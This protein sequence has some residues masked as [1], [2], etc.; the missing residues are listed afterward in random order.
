VGH[1][2]GRLPNDQGFDEWW[3]YK[4]SAAE[5]GY[6]SWP[7]FKESGMPAPM[8]WEGKKGERS[9]PVMPFY[10]AVQPL[11]DGKYIVPKTVE[12]IKRSAAAK[13]PFFVYVGYS[14]MHP[15]II[16]HP[17]FVGKST[18]RSGLFAVG[19]RS[20]RCFSSKWKEGHFLWIP[21]GSRFQEEAHYA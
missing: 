6:T 21:T 11:M 9:K 16:G 4:N 19:E 20:D 2:E 10:L 18:E 17:D 1:S 12:Y 5:A 3:G 7:W 13:K 15:P 8:I 14:E